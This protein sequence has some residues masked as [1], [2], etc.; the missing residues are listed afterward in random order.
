MDVLL[1]L[2]T[3]HVAMHPNFPFKLPRWWFPQSFCGLYWKCA[4]FNSL[5]VINMYFLCICVSL[6]TTMYFIHG[7]VTLFFANNSLMQCRIT[8]KFSTQFFLDSKV[9]F[10]S[11]TMFINAPTKEFILCCTFCRISIWILFHFLLLILSCSITIVQHLRLDYCE[12]FELAW[13]E[14]IDKSKWN[15]SCF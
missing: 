1:K 6:V 14:T 3:S 8:M 13:K 10:S 2:G 9:I 12:N 11:H 4:Q 7:R 15:M 5:T